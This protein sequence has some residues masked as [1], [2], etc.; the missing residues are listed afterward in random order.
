M[1][2][3]GQTVKVNVPE[4]MGLQ[5]A[6]VLI[7]EHGSVRVASRV[8][9]RWEREDASMKSVYVCDVGVMWVVDTGK[10]TFGEVEEGRRPAKG[11]PVV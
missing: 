4:W 8:V 1:R 6:S 3:S 9:Q 11:R 2:C 10:G 5:S 7:P